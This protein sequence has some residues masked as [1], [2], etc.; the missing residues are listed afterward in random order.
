[1]SLLLGT[2]DGVWYLD[3]TGERIGLAGRPAISVAARERTLLAAVPRDGLYRL[4]RDGGYCG[5]PD[6]VGAQRIWSGDARAAAVGP[7]GS[8]YV[9][10]EPAKLLRSIDGGCTW[11]RVDASAAPA[12]GYQRCFTGHPRA[13][14]RSI[15]FLADEPGSVLIGTEAGGIMRT[16][17]AGDTWHQLNRGIHADVHAVRPDPTAP[18]RLIAVTGRGVYLSEDG[19]ASWEKT[20]AGLRQSYAIGLDFNPER[21]GEVLVTTADRPPGLNATVSYSRDGGHTWAPVAHPAVPERYDRVPVVLFAEDSAW[22]MTDRG[23]IFRTDDVRG[24]W[25]LHDEIFAP[26][27]AASAGGSPSLVTYDLP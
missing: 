14:V 5:L 21:A 7:D 26:I 22:I 24:S 3:G 18:G 1:M 27:F 12:A 6:L 17:D 13:R 25:S 9:A 19:G 20:T 16:R 23:Q 15:D 8:L 4:S 2:N 11:C 10:A